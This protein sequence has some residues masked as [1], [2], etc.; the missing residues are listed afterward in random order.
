MENFAS[1]EKATAL[2]TLMRLFETTEEAVR[3]SL[4][5]NADSL[6]LWEPY[7]APER[8]QGG[9]VWTS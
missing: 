5:V 6:S 1:E 3:V 2:D 9:Q 4:T 8:C 7:R